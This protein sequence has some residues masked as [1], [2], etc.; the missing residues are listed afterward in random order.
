M[1]WKREASEMLREYEAMRKSL[2]TLPGELARLELERTALQSSAGGGE[3]VIGGHGSSEDRIISNM[4]KREAA[5]KNLELARAHVALVEKGLSVLDEE[6]RVALDLMI[7]NRTKGNVDRLCERW[8]VEKTEV[9][10]RKDKAL[11][12]FTLALYG[13][14]ETKA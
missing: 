1:D 7:V 10:R 14:T 3:P 5:E 6:E 9:Y 12:T 8:S 11:R 13:A 4:M 2:S